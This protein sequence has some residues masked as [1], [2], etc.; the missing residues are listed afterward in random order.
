[1]LFWGLKEGPDSSE[2]SLGCGPADLL[3]SPKPLN[4]GNMNKIRKK[5][6]MPHP[7]WA[8]IAPVQEAFGSLGSKDLLHPPL[9]TLA[10]CPFSGNFPGPRPPKSASE[11]LF[12]CDTG[13]GEKRCGPWAQRSGMSAGNSAPKH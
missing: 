1:M 13:S 12:F 7:G 3:Q 5:Y 8:Q 11:R 2:N 9:T 10:V 4:P 6:K